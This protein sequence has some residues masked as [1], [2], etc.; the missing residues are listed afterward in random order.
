MDPPFMVD[1]EVKPPMLM[2]RGF[3]PEEH[4]RQQFNYDVKIPFPQGQ[5][6]PPRL[7]VRGIP[8]KAYGGIGPDSG[9]QSQEIHYSDP[10]Y[11]AQDMSYDDKRF[12]SYYG[13]PILSLTPAHAGMVGILNPGQSAMMNT[14]MHA[15]IPS[16]MAPGISSM[17]VSS[18]SNMAN[19]GIGAPMAPNMTNMANNMGTNMGT[20]MTGMTNLVP[21]ITS[22]IGSGIGPVGAYDAN[23][24]S[25]Q[26][27][28][29]TA[30]GS[31]DSGIGPVGY[32]IN[33]NGHPASLPNMQPR[34]ATSLNASMGSSMTHSNENEQTLNTANTSIGSNNALNVNHPSSTFPGKLEEGG[35]LVSPIPPLHAQ[36]LFVNKEEDGRKVESNSHILS[37]CSRCK[38][39][40]TQNLSVSKG[41]FSG[42]LGGDQKIYKLCGHCRD[43]Q[44]ERLRRWQKKTKDKQGACRRCGNDIPPEQQKYVLCPLCRQNLRIRK[45]NRAAQGK[46]VH[47][48]GPINL[49]VINDEKG[50]ENGRRSSILG[51]SYKVCQRCR[52]NDKIRRTNLERLG[53]CNRC[54]KAL[55]SEEQGRHKVCLNCR[56][57]KKKIGSVSLYSG[58]PGVPS[59]VAM[60]SSQQPQ[61]MNVP[62]PPQKMA[63]MNYVLVDQ[64]SMIGSVAMNQMMNVSGPVSQQDYVPPYPQMIHLPDMYKAQLAQYPIQQQPDQIPQ[65]QY[66]LQ[67][68]Q[69]NR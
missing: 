31:L 26:N 10:R 28:Q 38:K 20:A 33:N 65:S 62:P 34:M 57:K 23:V 29:N 54:A 3:V 63:H 51:G 35:G 55:S 53:N 39:D 61:P 7:S 13:Y 25:T 1:Q 45:A 9:M 46:C 69:F 64:S 37:K 27:P 40:F 42:K 58:F 44:R 60:D 16:T 17:G 48:S 19:M 8:M 56:Q 4:D 14:G 66:L 50:D 12:K 6:Y 49:L 67:R 52:E 15:A 11:V 32:N 43:L 68:P 47:C 22:S 18:G 2:R 30:S 59:M 24:N 21:A 5:Y 41:S 36:Q